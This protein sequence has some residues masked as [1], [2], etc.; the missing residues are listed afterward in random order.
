MPFT[1]VTKSR[2]L[3]LALY[4]AFLLALPSHALGHAEPLAGNCKAPLTHNFQ[5]P[6]SL[7]EQLTEQLN[8]LSFQYL[9]NYAGFT[10]T[11]PGPPNTARR[12]I[13]LPSWPDDFRQTLT[14]QD[15]K[16]KREHFELIDVGYKN[17]EAFSNRV[18]RLVL[19]HLLEHTTEDLEVR[20]DNWRIYAGHRMIRYRWGVHDAVMELY[21]KTKP[22]LNPED[23]RTLSYLNKQSGNSDVLALLRS[24]P[25]EEPSDLLTEPEI[26]ERL[27]LTIQISYL[28]THSYMKAEI[29][30]L[31]LNGEVT[32]RDTDLYPFEYRI[33]VKDRPT[34][35]N[36]VHGRFPVLK[37]CE[38]LRYGSF[39]TKLPQAVRDRFLFQAFERA[40]SRGMRYIIAGADKFTA[41]LYKRYGFQI[42]AELPIAGQEKE[43]LT[44]VD[45]ES[46][47]FKTIYENLRVS[48]KQVRVK[49]EA[50]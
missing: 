12:I 1:Q 13:Q 40:R 50:I 41:R 42:F 26:N 44:Y 30:S 45:M 14:V 47:E 34:F 29:P 32:I 33:E 3:L 16:V 24:D 46:P 23:F 35:R 10:L 27:V 5:S 6:I 18:N 49:I 37:T 28:K 11:H 21:K 39:D 17:L 48:G 20:F 4:F 9:P 38:M 22:Y 31:S 7:E 25:S 15:W 43:Y 36:K 8:Q 2:G 19:D